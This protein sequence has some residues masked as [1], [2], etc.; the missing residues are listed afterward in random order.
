MSIWKRLR[1]RAGAGPS[2]KPEAAAGIERTPAGHVEIVHLAGAVPHRARLFASSLAPDP[3]H[4]LLVV[5]LPESELEE[6]AGVLPVGTRGVRLV[7]VPSGQ[8][9]SWVDGQSLAETLG[10]AVLLPHGTVRPSHAGVSF[11][12]PLTDGRWVRYRPGAEATWAGRRL[13]QPSWDVPGSLAETQVLGKDVVA[14][15]L[16]SGVWLRAAGD[17]RWIRAARARLTRWVPCRSDEILVALGAEGLAPLPIDVVSRWWESLVGP[18]RELLRFV[19]FGPVRT[20]AGKSMG[21][22]LSDSTGAEIVVYCGLPVHSVNG[23]EV[24]ALRPDGSH[25]W[26][27]F[28]HALAYRPHGTD[29]TGPVAPVLRAYRKPIPRLP[30]VAAGIYRYDSDTVVEV[31]PAGLW[32]RGEDEPAYSDFVRTLPPD[33]QAPTVF[34]NAS[35]GEMTA[36]HW[37][38]A[39]EVAE[40]LRQTTGAA[41]RVVPTDGIEPAPS[42]SWVAHPGKREASGEPKIAAP[43]AEEQAEA[44][45][46]LVLLMQLVGGNQDADTEDAGSPGL[47]MAVLETDPPAESDEAEDPEPIHAA[48]DDAFV[49]EQGASA[50]SVPDPAHDRA[51]IRETWPEHFA[52]A[53]DAEDQDAFTDLMAARLHLGPLG[54]EAGMD[55]TGPLAALGRRAAEGIVDLPRHRGATAATV[56]PDRDQW[57]SLDGRAVLVEPGVCAMSLAPPPIGAG[58]TDLLV[59]SMSG[60]LVE[61]PDGTGK[62]VV[63]PPGTS[64]AVL[65]VV[66]PADGLRGRVLLRELSDRELEKRARSLD[67]L[68]LSSLRQSAER[69]RRTEADEPTPDGEVGRL[70]GMSTGSVLEGSLSR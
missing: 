8:D 5:D 51:L 2:T 9:L 16:P 11:D 54:R 21:Q 40:R 62:G 14:E 4:R 19:Q 34:H 22:A 39:E 23:P 37:Q 3:H 13:P 69:W 30:K 41:V 57:A 26:P 46:P 10:S 45:E 65:D 53:A 24:V 42:T 67:D 35:D 29:E 17:D 64:F 6:L 48:P 28:A 63:F 47:G 20:A 44:E 52:G 36:H 55:A 43:V 1:A 56:A 68:I 59:W 66:E 61:R 18:R 33:P 32:V 70:P 49:P 12:D 31:V 25:G 58:T 38:S 7:P 50:D 27:M 60:R 15:P